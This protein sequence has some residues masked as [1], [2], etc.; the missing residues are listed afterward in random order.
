MIKV[1]KWSL[2]AIRLIAVPALEN[3]HK[4]LHEKVVATPDKWDDALCGAFE[5]VIEFLK[6][7]DAFEET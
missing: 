2:L 5:M 4:A 3:I 6:A 1:R 7:P